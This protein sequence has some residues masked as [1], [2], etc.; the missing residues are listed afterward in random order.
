MAAKTLRVY[1]TISALFLA[2]AMCLPAQAEDWPTFR[3]DIS[4]SGITDE[5]LPLPLVESWVFKCRYAPKPA[6]GHGYPLG[7]NWE[8]GVEKRRIDFD[9]ADSTVA[10]GKS[11][12]FGSVGDGKVYC[13]DAATGKVRWTHAT[14]GPVRLAPT[15]YEGKVYVGSDDGWVYCLAA[16]DGKEV[17]KFRAAPEDHRVIGNGYV[18][19]LWPVRTGVMVDSGIAYF[20]SGIFISEG[21]FLYAVDAGTGK[22]IW[23]NDRAYENRMNALSPQGYLLARTD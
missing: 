14:G 17:W 22:L 20:A 7:T 3:R 5:D 2:I 11:V 6:F 10:V 23:I 1:T 15:V 9:R 19:S 18:V 4:R 21:V 8:G 12:F 16:A 13:L